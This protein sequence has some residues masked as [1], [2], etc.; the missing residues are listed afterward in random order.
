MTIKTPVVFIIFNRPEIT[1]KTF[2]VIREQKPSQLFII[3]DGPRLGNSADVENCKLARDIVEKIDWEC[4]VSTNYS[5][6]NLGCKNR[7]ISGLNWVFEKVDKAI[8]IEDDCLAGE[9]FFIFCENLLDRYA[10]DERVSVITGDNFQNGILRGNASYYFSKYPHIWG[11]ATWKETWDNFDGDIKFWPKWRISDDF[12]KKFPTKLERNFWKKIFDQSFLGKDDSWGY[13]L[14][15]SI[16]RQGTY[17]ATPNFNLISNIGF[18]ETSTHTKDTKNKL[19]NV[20]LSS[21]DKLTHPTKIEVN[22]E[23]DNYDFNNNF[24]DK[25]LLFPRNIISFPKR[26]K[27][28]IVRKI[29]KSKK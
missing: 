21:I 13:P 26:L 10:E 18:G 9:D 17:T 29:Y 27:N 5:E 20:K 16:M 28:F 15:A 4:E 3:A 12:K 19:S 2:S 22:F 25:N 1:K 24:I 11:W 23:A 14:F 8:I 7:V 6:Q